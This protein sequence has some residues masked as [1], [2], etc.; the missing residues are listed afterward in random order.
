MAPKLNNGWED[1]TPVR[2]DRKKYKCNYCENVVHGWITRHRQHIAHVSENIEACS[3]VPSEIRKM[4]GK[5]L[6]DGIKEKTASLR[7]KVLINIVRED[8]LYSDVPNIHAHSSDEHGMSA[9][10]KKQLKH[11]IAESRYM[12]HVEEK[13]RRK[14]SRGAGFYGGSCKGSTSGAKRGI[15]QNYGIKSGIEMPSTGLDPHI[16]SFGKRTIKGILSK[17]GMKKIMVLICNQ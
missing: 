2:G 8:S 4:V 10:E 5:L 7:R 13:I 3:R 1:A 16:F 15:S 11:A 14:P 9:L 6:D 12:G 17:E